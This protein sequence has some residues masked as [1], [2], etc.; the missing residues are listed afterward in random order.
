MHVAV[1]GC[2]WVGAVTAATLSSLGHTVIGHDIVPSRVAALQAGH[3]PFVE[4]DLA[5]LV[6][7]GIAAGRLSFTNDMKSVGAASVAFLCVPSPSAADGSAD[8]S[9]VYA[10][11]EAVAPHLPSGAV[12]VIKSTVPPGTTAELRRRVQALRPDIFVVHSPEFLAESTAVRDALQPSRIVLGVDDAAAAEVLHAL[13]ASYA[14]QGTTIIDMT[15]V[16]AELAKYAAN[17]FLATK[18][19]FV[20][21][22]AAIADA[23]GADAGDVMRSMASDERIGSKF[24]RHGVG[25][26]GGCF[27]KDVAALAA[28]GASRNVQLNIVPATMA[29]NHLA[30]ERYVAKILSALERTAGKSVAILGLAFKPNTD[31]VRDAPALFIMQKLVAA[32]V[33]VTAYDP[34]IGTRLAS[35]YPAVTFYTSLD[36]AVR[37]ADVVFI[38]TEWPEIITWANASSTSRV[39]INGRPGLA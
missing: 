5:E 24:L 29:T 7:S 3:V 10:A 34:V 39:V 25:Y 13:Y 21:E 23:V 15:S 17:A 20:N 31:D 26:G 8:C 19:S 30:R 36:D 37:S 32:G 9:Y 28:L 11:G 1:I 33:A 12:I 22:I 4:P 14:A 6:Q 18:V 38:A 16:S 2:G 35:D 27:P